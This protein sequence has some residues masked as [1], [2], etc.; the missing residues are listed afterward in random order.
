M[1]SGSTNDINVKN[2]ITVKKDPVFDCV[3]SDKFP[4]NITI[5]AIDEVY[6][7]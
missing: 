4:V 3:F 2:L 6:L 1:D 7:L 5:E